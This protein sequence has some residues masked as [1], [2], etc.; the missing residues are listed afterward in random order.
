MGGNPLAYSDYLGLLHPD[1]SKRRNRKQHKGKTKRCK[2]SDDI[3]CCLAK[4]F[5]QPESA[6][7]TVKIIPNS[8]R[9]KM[10][11]IGQS[12]AY[13]A[14][15]RKNAIWLT[16]E[17]D[18][19]FNDNNFMLHEFYHVFNQWNNGRMGRLSYLLDPDKWENEADNFANKNEQSFAGCLA[20]GC[21]PCS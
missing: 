20:K 5:G 16:N 14:T 19:L 9:A 6:V 10:H 1:N 2:V 11:F 8:V 18:T 15:T 7:D 3:K 17:C 21:T 12:Y 4:T 13:A